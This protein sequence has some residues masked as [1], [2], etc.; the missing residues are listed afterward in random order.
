M[1][2]KVFALAAAIFAATTLFAQTGVGDDVNY[3]GVD[4]SKAKV[5]G[6]AETGWDF[7]EAFGRINSLVIAEW[8]KYDPGKFLN[9]NV[10]VR[11]ISATW[12][13]NG[14]IEQS[15]ILTPSSR[16]SLGEADVDAMVRRYELA[17][18]EGVGL[19]LVGEM[20]DKSVGTGSFL[21]V[22]FDVA[23]RRVLHMR[24]IEGRA[25][26]L[27]LRNYW[28]GALYDALKGRR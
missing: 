11:D 6:A 8:P 7:K 13:V 3:Y 12:H 20:L 1:M 2:K 22:C 5:F 21:V 17:E 9:K 23:S 18:T 19:V 15:E 24:R 14:A 10:D 4:F 28:A 25:R 26:G 16:H 27:G